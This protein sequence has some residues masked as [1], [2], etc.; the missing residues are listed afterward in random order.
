M[1]FLGEYM[2]QRIRSRAQMLL[3]CMEHIEMKMSMGLND[4][5]GVRDVWRVCSL[6]WLNGGDA[7]VV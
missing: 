4:V 2:V 3:D 6:S 7:I 1:S 5:I